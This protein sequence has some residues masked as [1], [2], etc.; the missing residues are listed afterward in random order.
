VHRR[1]NLLVD[2]NTDQ[3][4]GSERAASVHLRDMV[5]AALIGVFLA[6]LPHL[7]AWSST[8][9]PVWFGDYDDYSVYLAIASQAYYHDPLHLG[10][11]V[12]PTFGR[13][14]Y[15]E[16]QMVP[17]IVLARALGAGPVGITLAWR[18]IAGA[19]MGAGFWFVTV[20]YVRSRWLALPLTI[21]LLADAG[22][23]AGWPILK[24]VALTVQLAL[25]GRGLSY[26]NSAPILTPIWRLITPALSAPFLLLQIGLLARARGQERATPLTLLGAGLGFGLLFYVYFYF[27]TAVALSLVLA[28]LI[29]A[30]YRRVYFHTA[31]VGAIVG[32]P[33]VISQALLK[34]GTSSD[35][36]HRSDL[37]LPIARLSELSFE[38]KYVPSLVALI[39]CFV[40][41]RKELL[42]LGT[43]A[44]AGLLLMNHQLISG[45][46]IQN[47]HWVYV[48]GIAQ[49]LLL[50]L[51]ATGWAEGLQGATRW[52]KPAAWVLAAAVLAAGTG[53]RAAE[54][55]WTR[56][57]REIKADYLAYRAQRA[58]SGVAALSP[59]SVCGGDP[60]FLMAVAALDDVRPLMHL[61]I[62][63][64]PSI[65]NEE[66][67]ARA[68]LNGYLRGQD[69][70][71][72]EADQ[73]RVLRNRNPRTEAYGVYGPWVAPRP[74]ADES[75][76][77]RVRSRVARYN[78][79][80]RDPV[81]ALDQFNVRYVALPWSQPPPAYLAR[82]WRL[83]Q[84]G[85][86][87][88]IW[89]RD[90]GVSTPVR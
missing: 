28:F 13:A 78:E 36:L 45:L 37:F 8:G 27:W 35:W 52:L 64:S 73:R 24:T 4:N 19:G 29:D 69:L 10:E 7:I 47:W 68:V 89:E 59:N 1:R 87:W 39:V 61:S 23:I 16:V 54:G 11:P 58:A 53:L 72:F 40:A 38:P 84:G 32:L 46:Q 30:G 3:S 26:L 48:V 67:D 43:L 20:R 22:Q 79:V 63:F 41:R 80:V 83:L 49:S 5:V 2:P 12:L 57:S 33:A 18:V 88:G 74:H 25:Q 60:V 62:L 15:P 70:S 77:T 90:R 65:T 6:V 31:W 66:W 81:H 34:A 82:D 42:H 51:L 71:A 9:A 86:T 75:L 14:F 50:L 17:G 56:F 76:D 85:P 44:I 55:A 21:I